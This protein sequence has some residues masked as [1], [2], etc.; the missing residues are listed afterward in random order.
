MVRVKVKELEVLIHQVMSTTLA[1][2]YIGLVPEWWN[3][4][5]RSCSYGIS[6]DGLF[7]GFKSLMV[8]WRLPYSCLLLRMC[9]AYADWGLLD[10]MYLLCSL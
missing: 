8:V 9:S 6:L 2:L 7:I 10:F 1:S 4:W 3:C 5:M